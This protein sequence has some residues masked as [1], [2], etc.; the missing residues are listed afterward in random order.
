M[1]EPIP[2]GSTG[3]KLSQWILRLVGFCIL[4]GGVVL[5][6]TAPIL[7]LPLVGLGVAFS[8]SPRR[9]GESLELFA[10]AGRAI[11]SLF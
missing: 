8:L 9:V 2:E 4:G 11:A 7:G 10:D 3:E 6:T 1:P 5:S